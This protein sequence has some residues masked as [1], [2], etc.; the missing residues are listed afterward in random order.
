M[1]LEVKSPDEFSR[2]GAVEGVGSATVVSDAFTKPVSTLMGPI[3]AQ[4]NVVI[5]QVVAHV[6]P[7]MAEFPAQRD[8]IRDE[9]RNLKAR[10]REEIFTMGLRKR[11]EQEKKLQLHN[12]VLKRIIDSYTRS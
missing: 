11:L 3:S 2:T 7:N 8:G 9:L 10:E 6:E 4:G 12:D 1:G 5:A